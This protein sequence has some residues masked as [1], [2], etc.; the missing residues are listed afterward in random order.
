MMPTGSSDLSRLYASS[1]QNAR[2]KAD[3]ARLTA[4]LSSGQIA[5]PVRRL[6]AGLPRLADMDRQLSLT[7]G[8]SRATVQVTQS[9]RIMQTSLDAVEGARSSLANNALLVS[10][11]GGSM[12]VTSVAETA[13]QG[14]ATTV[15]ALNARIG[16]QSLFA[17][18]ATDTAPLAPADRMLDALRVAIAGAATVQDAVDAVD[19]WF[20]AGGGFHTD[21]YQGDSGVPLSRQV[22][23]GVTVTIPL[24][25]DDPALTGILAATAM[26]ALADDPALIFSDEARRQLVLRAGERL[27][28]ASEPLVQ[29]AAR[30][31]EAEARLDAVASTHAARTSALS[32][33][34]TEL[35]AAD[36]FDA[37]AVLRQV[38]T[39]LE[40]HYALTARL[41]RLSLADYL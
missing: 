5:D 17:G 30:L 6:G 32:L 25:A 37:A 21:G 4:E 28:T 38:Q 26:A 27:L 24:R 22:D 3:L 7:E 36:P 13:R 18:R 23:Q 20:A 1:G 11:T 8:F 34:R 9:L 40:T 35:L 14:F 10:G 31:G 16:D 29:T 12:R 41:S 19:A 2:L 39:Q 33:M 15:S